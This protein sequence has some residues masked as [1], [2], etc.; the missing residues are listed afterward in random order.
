MKWFYWSVWYFGYYVIGPLLAMKR[1]GVENIPKTGPIIVA[2]NHQSYL[3]PPLI[4]VTV[5]REVHFFA[6]KE[7]FDIPLLNWWIRSLNAIPV[8]RG[9][10]D[11]QALSFVER[12]LSAGGGL[13][14]FPEGTRDDG[15]TFLK[16]KAGVGLLARRNKAAIVPTFIFRSHKPLEAL[17]N[18]RGIWI[19]FGPPIMPDEVAQYEDNKQGYQK[20][21]ELVMEKIGELKKKA[22]LKL[23]DIS[24]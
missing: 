13:V 19:Y 10:F 18:R 16:P 22:L 6:K 14:M 12:A 15:E 20:L 17:I 7:L 4:G 21:A 5:N 9:V 24:D 8:R 23:G 11:P 2:S 3:D 1:F